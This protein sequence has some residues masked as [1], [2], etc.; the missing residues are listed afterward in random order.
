MKLEFQQHVDEVPAVSAP[1]ND[2]CDYVILRCSG[3]GV[4]LNFLKLQKL[5]YYCQAWSLAFNRGP[6]FDGKFQAWVHGPVNRQIYD[7]FTPG[8][9]L[10][11]EVHLGDVVNPNP[12]LTEADRLLVDK[13]LEAYAKFSG[14]DLERMSH[15]EKPWL[16]ARNGLPSLARCETAI[17]EET[18]KS[19]YASRLS[20]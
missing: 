15:A 10:Y 18:M 14:V 1:L 2:V 7:R 16:E 19:Y 5:L 6:L 20:S 8:K 4:D 12:M 9:S 3:A 17:N 11:S 13:V